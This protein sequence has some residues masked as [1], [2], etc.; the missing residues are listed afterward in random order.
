MLNK[1]V[2]RQDLPP[3]PLKI[4]KRSLHR[5]IVGFHSPSLTVPR[6]G[7]WWIDQGGYIDPGRGITHGGGSGCGGG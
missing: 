3:L 1:A 7:G 5:L 2:Q 6:L 4:T